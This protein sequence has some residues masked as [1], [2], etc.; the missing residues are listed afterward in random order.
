MDVNYLP[1]KQISPPENETKFVTKSR[2]KLI[3]RVIK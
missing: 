3:Y 2:H 1:V